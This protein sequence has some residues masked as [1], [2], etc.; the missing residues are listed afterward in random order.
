MIEVYKGSSN[1]HIC[2]ND[3]NQWNKCGSLKTERTGI[4]SY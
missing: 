3:L 1:G 4:I 2:F